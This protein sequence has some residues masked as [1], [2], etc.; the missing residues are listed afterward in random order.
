MQ[1]GKNAHCSSSANKMIL[2]V[3]ITSLSIIIIAYTVD[4]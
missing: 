2:Y 4:R 3:A 1:S